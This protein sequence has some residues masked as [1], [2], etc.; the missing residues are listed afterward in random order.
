MGVHRLG[1]EVE[2]DCPLMG[3]YQ[4]TRAWEGLEPT[5][6]DLGVCAG[7]SSEARSVFFADDERGVAGALRVAEA[8]AHCVRCEVQGDC[9]SYALATKPQG[10]WGGLTEVERRTMVKERAAAS[11]VALRAAAAAAS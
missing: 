10:I 9:L 2:H 3:A 5:W 6:M 7:L 11:R 4:I 1:L 8:K